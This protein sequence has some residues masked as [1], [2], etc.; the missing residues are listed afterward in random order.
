M[1]RGL[2]RIGNREVGGDRPAFIIAEAGVNHNGGVD[3]AKK[4]VDAAV[5]AGVDAVK[6]QTFKAAR[7][8]SR[9]APK[10]AYQKETT[11]VEESQLEMV[12]QLELSAEAHGE[13]Q[14]YCQSH[15]I[16]FLSTPF[17]S[18]SVDLLDSLDV[19]AFKVG[20]GEI[21][22]WPLLKYIGRKGKPVILSTGM[23][24]LSEVDEAMRVLRDAGNDQLVLLHCVSDYPADP[25]D[26]NLRAMQGMAAAFQ[27][28]VGY[29][30]H[31]TG[32]EVALA[33]VAL[34]ACVIEKHFTLDR[35]LLGPD[36]R[37][38]LEAHDLQSMVDGIRTVEW[39]LG[40]GVKAPRPSEIGIRAIGRRSLVAAHEIEP[41]T[42]ITHEMLAAK[43][44]GT[45]IQPRCID[46]LVGRTA[47]VRILADQ[48]IKPGMIR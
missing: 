45:G 14:A 30:D 5:G 31:T 39:A 2:V 13:L 48:L 20:S 18:Q 19:P 38:S 36:H 27:V 28:P 22:N 24:Y 17:D 25:A 1:A 26:T 40:D 35:S 34:G 8:V 12:R 42:T 33:A 23:S 9:A 11:D 16:L 21:T 46:S 7:L 43:R 47:A 29:S 41:G 4:M 15:R 10:A 44:P 37:I 6:F 32:I 3:L